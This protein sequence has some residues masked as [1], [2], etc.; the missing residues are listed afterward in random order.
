VCLNKLDTGPELAG[1][2]SSDMNFLW[3]PNIRNDQSCRSEQSTYTIPKAASTSSSTQSDMLVHAES[4]GT[5]SPV[6]DSVTSHL[7]TSVKKGK[8][9]VQTYKPE[10]LVADS[11]QSLQ[12]SYTVMRPVTQSS[13]VPLRPKRI[14]GPGNQ[15][16]DKAVNLHPA[17]DT[18]PESPGRT[19][20]VI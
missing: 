16:H 17:S 19:T 18:A 9:D 3:S 11:Q 4:M 10:K 6:P 12:P 15:L 1:P 13:F 14:P 2:F 20:F 7:M 5:I 8:T